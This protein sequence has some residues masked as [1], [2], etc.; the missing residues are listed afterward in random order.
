MIFIVWIALCFAVGY[1]AKTRCR[2][3]WTYVFLSVIIS[4]IG[5]CIVLLLVGKKNTEQD[6]SR[7]DTPQSNLKEADT[8]FC[9]SCGSEIPANSEFC[10]NCGKRIN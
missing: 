10:P 7:S 2:N 1:F 3:F 8:T 9:H 6:A 5:G 4:P